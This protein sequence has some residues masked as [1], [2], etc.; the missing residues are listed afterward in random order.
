MYYFFFLKKTAI[1]P[2]TDAMISAIAG[3]ETIASQ[4]KL[5]RLPILITFPP[6]LFGGIIIPLSYFVVK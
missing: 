4:P 6:G 5:K 3:A 2:T 1:E